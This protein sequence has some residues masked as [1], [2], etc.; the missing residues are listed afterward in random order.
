MLCESF[1]HPIT[2]S[3]EVGETNISPFIIGFF[4]FITHIPLINSITLSSVPSEV[5]QLINIKVR[6]NLCIKKKTN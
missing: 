4:R 3:A 2:K 5:T 6:I 1:A